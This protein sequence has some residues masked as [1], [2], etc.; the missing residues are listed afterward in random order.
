M[1]ISNP[2]RVGVITGTPDFYKTDSIEYQML[3]LKCIGNGYSDEIII[4]FIEG[5][6]SGFDLN[7]DASK[8][9]SHVPDVPQI[10]IKNGNQYF[11]INTLP[12]IYE[13]LAIQLDFRCGR[14]GYYKLESTDRT[15]LEDTVEVYLKDELE[16]KL[17][18]FR[19]AG[20][21]EFFHHTSNNRHRFTIYF[22]PS[23]DVINNITKE[24]YYSIYSHRNVISVLKHTVKDMTGEVHVHNM[25][26]QPVCAEP[27]YNSARCDYHLSV[28]TGY[29]IV[30][31]VTPLHIYNEKVFLNN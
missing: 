12:E 22:N 28:P 11:A 31:V 24:T 8:L 5:T 20:A 2:T 1:S 15:F 7:Y 19:S 4:R 29:Y 13:D 18:D 26:G 10:T 21:Y 27:L 25:L 14:E 9:F 3:D 23:P 6:S 17:I 30:T 16:Q